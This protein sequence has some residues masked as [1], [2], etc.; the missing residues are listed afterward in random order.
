MNNSDLRTKVLEEIQHIPEDQLD[1]LYQLVHSFLL[2]TISNHVPQNLMKFAG[3]WNDIPNEI[4]TEWVEDISVRRQQAFSQRQNR[5][6]N[7]D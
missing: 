5:E 3:C 6:A 1:D 7:F 4:Y 2:N